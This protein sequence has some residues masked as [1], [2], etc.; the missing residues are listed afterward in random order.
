MLIYAQSVTEDPPH[1]HVRGARDSF[2]EVSSIKFKMEFVSCEL[3]GQQLAL[4]SVAKKQVTSMIGKG[5]AKGSFREVSSASFE[6]GKSK[7]LADIS[8]INSLKIYYIYTFHPTLNGVVDAQVS[9]DLDMNVE[10]ISLV[11]STYY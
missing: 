7:I 9:L 2:R 11:N 1:K 10:S 4:N 5:D 3:W 6:K 8:F